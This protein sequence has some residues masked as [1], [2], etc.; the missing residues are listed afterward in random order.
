MRLCAACQAG[1]TQELMKPWAALSLALFTVGL[2]LSFFIIM[3]RFRN[4][5]YADQ[6][7]RERNVGNSPTTNPNF[8]VR[9]RFE[10]MYRC[11]RSMGPWGPWPQY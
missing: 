7:L 5:I 2:P 10:E 3:Y 9:K 11:E 6:R 8:H 1:G 4:E